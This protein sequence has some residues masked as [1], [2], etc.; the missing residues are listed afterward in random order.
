MNWK[1]PYLAA[2]G[3]ALVMAG[4]SAT[5]SHA[6]PGA[7]FAPPKQ[8]GRTVFFKLHLDGFRI[9]A[10]NVGKANRRGAG[11]IHFSMDGGKYDYQVFSGENGKLAAALGI[12]GKY[13]PAV[14]PMIAYTGLPRG[15]HRLV[16]FL[17]NND[18]SNNGGIAVIEFEVK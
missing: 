2:A 16:A 1:L 14:E 7:R 13:S 12:A 18:H 5:E 9:D 15:K 6:K 11:H 3:L 8:V 4:T 17:V 10:A